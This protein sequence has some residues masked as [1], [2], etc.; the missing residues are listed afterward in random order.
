MYIAIQ[1]NK[2][3]LFFS[4]SLSK[5]HTNTTYL[6]LPTLH[7]QGLSAACIGVWCDS[8]IF[9]ED[10]ALCIELLHAYNVQVA[11]VPCSEFET[12][13]HASAVPDNLLLLYYEGIYKHSICRLSQ[14]MLGCCQWM[15]FFPHLL[16]VCTQSDFIALKLNREF[17]IYMYIN[18][19]L[20]GFSYLVI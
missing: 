6:R 8:E 14:L 10:F 16:L 5:P 9:L 4:V 15:L 1:G 19:F 20:K 3:E 18:F 7:L 11:V 13:I 12:G 2:T 17:V